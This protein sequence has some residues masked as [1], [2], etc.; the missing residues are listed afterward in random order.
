M[1]KKNL[2]VILLVLILFTLFGAELKLV[3]NDSTGTDKLVISGSFGSFKYF[4]N[5]RESIRLKDF[6]LLENDSMAI[7]VYN[8]TLGLENNN[9]FYIYD[10]FNKY[11]YLDYEFENYL[12]TIPVEDSIYTF[13]YNFIYNGICSDTLKRTINLYYLHHN[14]TIQVNKDHYCLLT[15]ASLLKD[16]NKIVFWDEPNP[17]SPTSTTSIRF[18]NLKLKTNDSL[19]IEFY[20]KSLKYL[21]KIK[22]KIKMII[23]KAFVLMLVL[24][25]IMSSQKNTI[26]R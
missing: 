24:L 16:L 4:Y 3:K 10:A 13:Y 7:N 5:S 21:N 1:K 8:D 11:K 15:T 9:I 2:L 12:R 18:S 14:D 25:R 6:D 17:F 26:L 20:D 19:T 22:Y 23:K